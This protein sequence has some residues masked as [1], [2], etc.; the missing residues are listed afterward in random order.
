MK[1][2]W[3]LF[4]QSVTVLLAAYFVVGTLKPQW[5]DYRGG[6]SGQVAVLEA[7]A[8]PDASV[9]AGSF[10]LAAQKSS[11][12]GGSLTTARMR[13]KTRME[14]TPGSGSFLV[15]NKTSPR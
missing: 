14:Q 7:P 8:S 11:Q 4:S 1:R 12:A 13:A 6:R 15:S 5:L 2:F 9:P 10:R 3:L